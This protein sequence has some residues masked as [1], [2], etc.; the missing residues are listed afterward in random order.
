MDMLPSSYLHWH[1]LL[2]HLPSIGTAIALC[3]MLAGLYLK[4][5]DLRRASLVLFVIIGLFTIPT[6]VTGAAARGALEGTS[7]ISSEA[8]QAHQDAASW[9]FIMLLFTGWLAWYALWQYR[10]F[11]R[12]YAWTLPGVLVLALLSFAAMFRTGRLGG[13][14]NH[15]EI[16]TA[17]V[18][19][20]AESWTADLGARVVDSALMWPMLEALHFMGMSV[21]FG[22]VLLVAVRVFGIVTNVPFSAFH[23]LLPL[24]VFG[25]VINIV[26]G[27]LFFVGDW[28]R[29]ITMT[30]SFFPKMALI[31]IG[32]I[33][34]LYFTIFDKPWALKPGDK[35]PLAAKLVAAVT[36]LAWAGV[37]TYGRLLPYLEGA[38]G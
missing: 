30:N 35:A 25:L 27:M 10:R 8:I 2:N 23:R 19:A 6:Y 3:L 5:V 7:G 28:G 26:T 38:G 22:V 15:P 21:L 33:A 11:G 36:L 29:Y 18:A 1:L 16:V 13:Y 32:G 20:G 37:I 14:I 9:G 17:Q 12:P 4:S 31:V 34:V 24:G